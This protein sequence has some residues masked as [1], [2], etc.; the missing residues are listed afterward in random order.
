MDFNIKPIQQN[1]SVSHFDLRDGNAILSSHDSFL[2]AQEA[3]KVLKPD[4][5][6]PNWCYEVHDFD[7][8]EIEESDLDKLMDEIAADAK[9][10]GGKINHQKFAARVEQTELYLETLNTNAFDVFLNTYHNGIDYRL[11]QMGFDLDELYADLL[12]EHKELL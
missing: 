7:D 1:G 10:N 8:D 12:N 3:L 6:I 4:H 9:Q 11:E 2:E 5:Q